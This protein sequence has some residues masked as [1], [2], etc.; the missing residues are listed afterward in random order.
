MAKDLK[1][2]DSII[3]GTLCK[4]RTFAYPS[5]ARAFHSQ[6]NEETCNEFTPLHDS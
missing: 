6:S 2:E 4:S 1:T 5:F 3:A